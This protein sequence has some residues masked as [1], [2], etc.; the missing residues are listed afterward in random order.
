MKTSLKIRD[1]K[2]KA[3]N[4]YKVSPNTDSAE[5]TA[6]PRCLPPEKHFAFLRRKPLRGENTADHG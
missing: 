6:E 4:D 5:L 3:K 1:Q 2:K